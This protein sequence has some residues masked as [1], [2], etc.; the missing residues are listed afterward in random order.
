[1]ARI[2]YGHIFEHQEEV[3]FVLCSILVPLSPYTGD[4]ISEKNISSLAWGRV[5]KGTLKW[6][7][8]ELSLCSLGTLLSTSALGGCRAQLCPSRTWCGCPSRD[9]QQ[10]QSHTCG[11]M[12]RSSQGPSWGEKT[13]PWY[14]ILSDSWF[15]SVQGGVVS[16]FTVCSWCSGSCFA[17]LWQSGARTDG[18]LFFWRGNLSVNARWCNFMAGV[19]HPF[20]PASHFKKHGNLSHAADHPLLLLG[21]GEASGVFLAVSPGAAWGA[22]DSKVQLCRSCIPSWVTTGFLSLESNPECGKG[23]TGSHREWEMRR[24]KHEA[25]QE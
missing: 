5:L 25:A 10:W 14:W 11:G 6:P 23:W 17:W 22:A 24:T 2:A 8:G 20:E 7:I 18:N 1:M 9:T 12:Q 19:R 3:S 21:A 13:N 15:L 16:S 4:G